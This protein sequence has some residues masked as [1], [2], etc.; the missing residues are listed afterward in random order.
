MRAT[1]N[2]PDGLIDEVQ[3]LSGEKTKT[4][5]I[6][7]VMEEYVRRR[8]ME[9]LL[10]LRGKVAIEYDWEREEEAELKAAEERERYAA[11]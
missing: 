1:L 2:I 8:K 7:T 5:A 11:R 10:A 4:Q 9:D 3:R 6:V